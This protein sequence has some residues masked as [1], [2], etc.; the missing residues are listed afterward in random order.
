MH[1]KAPLPPCGWRVHE[2]IRSG[3]KHINCCASSP[4]CSCGDVRQLGEAL[5]CPCSP[6]LL[7]LSSPPKAG[8]VGGL[9]GFIRSLFGRGSS[10]LRR[11][12]SEETASVSEV[13][14]KSAEGVLAASGVG[15]TE[16][17]AAAS[18]ASGSGAGDVAAAETSGMCVPPCTPAE[19][20][21][22]VGP[23][24]PG[25]VLNNVVPGPTSTNSPINVA[26]DSSS[27]GNGAVSGNA[28]P[29]APVLYE[30]LENVA[31]ADVSQHVAALS[32]NGNGIHSGGG[33][34]R[35]EQ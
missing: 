3:T 24:R 27:N 32:G 1:S 8:S 23:V 20:P 21:G 30:W 2:L 13:N 25:P 31:S 29:S 34:R 7:P 26:D 10:S 28:A 15:D 19:P 35:G 17:S 4:G 5:R 12:S 11:E 14:E 18:T 33:G 9:G 16:S 22:T 6:Q